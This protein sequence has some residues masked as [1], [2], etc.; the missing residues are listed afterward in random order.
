MKDIGDTL[1]FSR[2]D[3]LLNPAQFEATTVT[4]VGLGSGGACVC[5]HLTMNGIRQ[6][7]LYDPDLLGPENLVKH[8]RLR[9]DIG[10]SK[11]HIQAEWI[12]DR[13]PRATVKAFP[14][15]VMKSDSFVTS[16]KSS[17]LVLCCPDT[18]SV[19]EFVNDVCVSAA[20]PCVTAS[21]FRT[22]IGGEV[23]GYVPNETGCYRCLQL[24]ALLNDMNLGDSDLALTDEEE[25]RIY[26]LNEQNF[27]AS[28]LSIDIQMIALI[29][30]RLGLAVLMRHSRSSIPLLKSNWIVFGN[31]PSKPAFTRHFQAHQMRLAPQSNCSCRATQT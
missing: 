30:V 9:S 8:P 29:Q 18:K 1:D 20:V 28:G 22:G 6:W 3:Y 14:E 15:D 4:I 2:I 16:V 25:H 19:R 24:Y 17:D 7:H 27:Q 21:V 5:D 12:M 13:N 10:R 31:R 11:V 23:Y 26:G